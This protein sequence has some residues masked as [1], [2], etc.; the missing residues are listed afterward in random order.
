MAMQIKTWMDK[1]IFKKLVSFFKRSI[2]GGISLDQILIKTNIM[3]RFRTMWIWPL[4]PYAMD[5][6]TSPSNVY[7]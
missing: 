5:E 3:A 4:N 2:L 7:T 6:K 1:F